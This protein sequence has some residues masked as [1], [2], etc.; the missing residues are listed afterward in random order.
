ME[1]KTIVGLIAVIAITVVAMFAGCIDKGPEGRYFLEEGGEWIYLD[2]KPDGAFS[3][4][5]DE[6]EWFWGTWKQ[7]GNRIYFLEKS[8][9][10]EAYWDELSCIFTGD[11]L[12]FD[13]IGWMTSSRD[14]PERW[15]KE[16]S[17]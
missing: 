14:L 11:T 8:G 12:I 2:I 13:E 4:I 15:I 6:D 7:K 16:G 3:L 9:K 1:K 10:E 5:V 17:W